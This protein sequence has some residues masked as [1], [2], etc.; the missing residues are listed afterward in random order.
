MEKLYQIKEYRAHLKQR[1][2]K[3]VIMLGFSDGTKDGGYLKANWGIFK[4]KEALTNIS[5]QYGIDVVFFDG[6]GGPPGRG[7]GN[8]YEFYASQGETIASTEFQLTI[9]GQTISSNYG[10]TASC[11]YNLEQLFCALIDNQLFRKESLKLSTKDRDL[12]EKLSDAAYQKY[13]KLKKHKAFVPYLENATPL[14]W[15]GD[16]NIGSRPAKRNQKDKLVFEDLRAIPFVGSWAQMKQNIPGYFG[17]GTA[18]EEIA[19]K[20]MKKD[21]MNLCEKSAFVQT[22]FSNSTQSLAKCNFSLSSWLTENKDFADFYQVLVDEFERSKKNILEVM[23]QEELMEDFPASK[24]SV[25]LREKIVLPL[26][27]IQQFALQMLNTQETKES[28]RHTYEKLTLR[29]MF[30]IINAARNSA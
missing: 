12:I 26:V 9:Q 14:R 7:G 23:Q 3:Q 30:G 10:K 15:F 29:C 2:S 28:E 8:T 17:I 22:L 21:L 5:K 24:A 27:A 13:L 25:M 20:K 11:K 19:D 1:N 6:R 4:A 18:I 16:T